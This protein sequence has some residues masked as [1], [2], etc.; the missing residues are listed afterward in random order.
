MNQPRILCVDYHNFLHR[1]RS[2]FT[3]GD[4][5]IIFNFFR[6]LRAQVE[7]HK[8]TRVIFADEGHPRA[9]HELLQPTGEPTETGK[10]V[11]YKA[12]RIIV[13]GTPQAMAHASF[14]RQADEIWKLLVTCFPVSLIRHHDYEADDTIYNVIKRSSSAV[15]WLVVSNDSDFTQLVQQFSWVQVYN[16]MSKTYVVPPAYDYVTWKALRGD[17]S[18]N[19]PGI[20]GVGDKTAEKLAS[21]LLVDAKEFNAFFSEPETKHKRS[22]IF[23]RNQKLIQFTDWSDEQALEMTSSSP[24]RDWEAVALAFSRWGFRSLLKEKTWEKFKSTFDPLFGQ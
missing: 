21:S 12:N 19:I 8:P 18:D 6:G 13:S 11:G 17:A 10:V 16:P 5:S 23:A 3:S 2:G 15:P 14:M 1:S 4:Y 22:E 7:L 9:K 24:T 20:P